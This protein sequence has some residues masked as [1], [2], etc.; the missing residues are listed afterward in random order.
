MVE[1]DCEDCPRCHSDV[2]YSKHESRYYC[3][4]CGYSLPTKNSVIQ[5]EFSEDELYLIEKLC[6]NQASAQ[7]KII[8]KLA[9]LSLIIPSMDI[10]G[11]TD[12]QLHK[13]LTKEHQAILDEF[14][15]WAKSSTILKS[16]RTKLE[17]RRNEVR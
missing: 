9:E 16:I 15:E 8:I 12:K 13:T 17:K 6:D 3:C 10:E 14:S 5:L 4:A 2:G 1:L 7:H 11:K